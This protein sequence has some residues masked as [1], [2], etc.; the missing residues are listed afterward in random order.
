MNDHILLAD[1]PISGFVRG[2]IA[3]VQGRQ[4][5]AEED[6]QVDDLD[7]LLRLQFQSRE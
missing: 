3:A 4:Q 1:L 6:T 5:S 2:A 7:N